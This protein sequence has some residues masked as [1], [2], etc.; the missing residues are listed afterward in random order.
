MV[1][2]TSTAEYY[3]KKSDTIKNN[4]QLKCWDPERNFF[5]HRYQNDED[6]GIKANTL[7]Y[8]SGKYKGSKHGR[9]EIG[10]IPWYFNLPSEGQGYENAWTQLMDSSGFCATYGPTTAERRHNGFRADAGELPGEHECQWKGPSWPFATSQTL[11]ALGNVLRN[12]SQNV[13]SKNDYLATLNCYT[14]SQRKDGH[15]WIAEDLNPL[16]GNWIADIEWR[17]EAYNHSTY[18]DLIIS[19]VV[20]LVA[21][22][23]STIEVNPLLPEDT[24]DYFCLD[25][26]LYHGHWL[27]I[28]YDKSG[29]HYNIGQGL[30]LYVDGNLAASSPTLSRITYS[31]DPTSKKQEQRPNGYSCL[32]ERSLVIAGEGKFFVPSSSSGS[33]HTVEVYDFSGRLLQTGKLRSGMVDIKKEWGLS[34]MVYLVRITTRE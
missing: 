32:G 9:E 4:F 10:F 13:V 30:F 15:A 11:V 33:Q 19:G 2:D 3:Q 27:T 34:N 21:R 1:G 29:T 22:E 25:R 17:S 12:Y 26:V 5:I 8:Q 16:T 18:N 6:N 23:D 20:G 7:T 14:R 24:W 31:G 28:V